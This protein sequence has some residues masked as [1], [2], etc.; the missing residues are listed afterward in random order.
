VNAGLQPALWHDLF[1]VFA[2]V[3]GALLGLFYVAMSLHI[4][5][6]GDRPVER[7]RAQAGLHALLVGLLMSLLVLIPQQPLVWLGLELIAVELGWL[8]IAIPAARRN[9][10][11]VHLT[12]VIWVNVIVGFV[13]LA[14][15]IIAGVSLIADKGPGLFLVVPALFARLLISSYFAWSVLFI[16]TKRR[17]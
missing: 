14:L 2:T 6:L 8:M 4:R 11:R 13:A 5:E 17:T 15:V 1:V 12:A 10:R 9:L 7:N 3:C 16:P